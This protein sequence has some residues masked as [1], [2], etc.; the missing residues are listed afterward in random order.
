MLH[1]ADAGGGWR[2]GAELGVC[3][4][5][6]STSATRTEISQHKA[7]AVR[8]LNASRWDWQRYFTLLMKMNRGIY[9]CQTPHL[10]KVSSIS[11]WNQRI[12]HYNMEWILSGWK[13]KYECL[14]G[15]IALLPYGS[16]LPR[17]RSQTSVCADKVTDGVFHCFCAELK[18]GV[19]ALLWVI[20]YGPHL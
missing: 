9:K 15:E 4:L 3:H 14:D 19:T 10:K 16:H 11:Q 18:P 7:A 17:W 13:K 20:Q 12:F 8:H 5:N 6:S 2:E 1:V